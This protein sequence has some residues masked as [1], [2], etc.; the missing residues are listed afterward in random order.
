MTNNTW[1]SAN[2]ILE[3]L[4]RSPLL[5]SLYR[6]SWAP[7]AYHFSLALLGAVI[8]RFPSRKIKV[9]GITGTKGK[10]TTVELINAILEA[11]GKRTAVL[12]SLRT[13]IVDRS[14]KNLFGN[15]MPGRFFIQNFFQEAVKAKCEYAIL[16]V[17]SQGV[18]LSRH[19]F[20]RWRSAAIT[21]LAPEHI[22]SHGSFE[23]YRAAKLA[24]LKKAAGMKAPVFLNEK[25]DH[26]DFF[27][28][29][30]AGKKIIPFSKDEAVNFGAGNPVL[31]SDFYRENM[32]LAYKVTRELGISEGVINKA[33]AEF[34]G[35]PGRF[36]FVQSEPFA[37]VVDYAHTPDSLEAIYKAVRPEEVFGRPGRLIAVLGAAGGG[38]DKWKRPKMGAIAAEYCD[39]VIL[40]NE[41][42]FDED[43]ESIL[44]EIE[45]GLFKIQNSKFKINNTYYK[46][47]DRKEAIKKA[48]ALARPGDCV[49][50]TGKGSE[51]YLR[52][53]G[54]KKIEWD[55]KRFAL[56]A[57]AAL[58][59]LSS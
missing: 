34:K 56:E 39:V 8:Y 13:K 46:I 26:Y 6:L 19:R 58:T 51:P 5:K 29:A 16:E 59:H 50:M 11:A 33:L 55:E 45:A 44:D 21:N 53:A 36:E 42:P 10:T 30:L 49:V 14:E 43:P 40:T 3:K 41:D 20:I 38:R 27:L 57:L 22:E 7:R 54:G 37:V 12:S 24:F 28:K 2:N 23:N 47:L 17:T 32:A 52:V 9:I 18:A 48:V 1:N 35:V 15:T 25:N 31:Q 4:K